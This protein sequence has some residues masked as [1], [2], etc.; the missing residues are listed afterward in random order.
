MKGPQTTIVH[1]ET[2]KENVFTFDFSY[3]SHDKSQ[4]YASQQTVYDDLGKAVLEGAW[5]GYNATLFAVE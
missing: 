4:P 2:G 1:P 5:E 3:W